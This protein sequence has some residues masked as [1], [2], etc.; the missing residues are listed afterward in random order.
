[1]YRS[2]RARTP[3]RYRATGPPRFDDFSELAS[4]FASVGCVNGAEHQIQVGEVIGWSR[5]HRVAC[6]AACW[7]RWTAEN[8]AA[9]FDER[10]LGN[11]YNYAAY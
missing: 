5:R 8:A 6:C 11:D 1:M 4:R 7:A 10:Q 3:R 9:D 2:R